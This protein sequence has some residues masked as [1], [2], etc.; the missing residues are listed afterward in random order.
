MTLEE[1]QAQ[2]ESYVIIRDTLEEMVENANRKI[3][4]LIDKEKEMARAS[5]YERIMPWIGRDL[6]AQVGEVRVFSDDAELMDAYWDH[7]HIDGAIVFLVNLEVKDARMI[8]I[9]DSEVIR[10]P[11][12]EEVIE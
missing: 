3:R 12:V 9:V 4:E 7:I 1:I 2:L 6:D 5:K 8:E 11:G 10:Y